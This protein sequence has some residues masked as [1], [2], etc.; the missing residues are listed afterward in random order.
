MADKLTLSR[1]M[2][3]QASLRLCL[4]WRRDLLKNIVQ[5]SKNSRFKRVHISTGLSLVYSHGLMISGVVELSSRACCKTA[6]FSLF[7]ELSNCLQLWCLNDLTCIG[8]CSRLLTL[9]ACGMY[10]VRL[11]WEWNMISSTT[12]CSRWKCWDLNDAVDLILTWRYCNVWLQIF[13]R[14]SRRIPRR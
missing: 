4:G 2:P 3:G 8:M 9:I 12:L 1:D 5:S 11:A 10:K 14:D 6:V 13:G 7:K